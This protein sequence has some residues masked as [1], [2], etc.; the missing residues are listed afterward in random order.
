MYNITI[1]LRQEWG[2]LFSNKCV[3]IKSDAR[4]M[5][6]VE[7][8]AALLR[9]SAVTDSSGLTGAVCE[10]VLS[11][12]PRIC[13]QAPGCGENVRRS[14]QVLRSEN[15]SSFRLAPPLTFASSGV[16]FQRW[17]GFK[18]DLFDV[19]S[20]MQ[21][22]EQSEGKRRARAGRGELERWGGERSA[23]LVYSWYLLNLCIFS[24]NSF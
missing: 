4:I 11:H 6:P 23:R 15:M 3:D 7:I 24:L 19:D 21:E 18:T 2:L 20:R 1:G 22:A 9:H 5:P 14:C 12:T 10:R 16:F 13:G 17:V 8:M